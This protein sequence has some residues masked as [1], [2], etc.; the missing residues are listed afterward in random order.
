M[1]KKNT[2]FI[3]VLVTATSIK[4]AEK[5]TRALLN[6]KLA[7]CVNIINNINSYFWWNK[8]IE[9][10]KE[11]LLIIKTVKKNF[12]QLKKEI[13]SIHSYEVPEIIALPIIKGNK[14]YLD[15]IVA[16]IK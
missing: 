3:V 14:N 16:S 6:K 7:A 9:K 15:W 1:I 12:A 5:I 4:E 2:Q 13:K 10:A 11:T 8:K